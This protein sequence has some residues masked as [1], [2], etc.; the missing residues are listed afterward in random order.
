MLA[1]APSWRCLAILI[2][3]CSVQLGVA[4]RASA[5]EP[6]DDA[7]AYRLGTATTG[8]TYH[9]VGVALSTLVKL[10]LLPAFG[11]DLTAVNTEGSQQNLDLMRRNDIQFAIISALAGHEAR[12]GVGAFVDA[13]PDEDLRAITTLWLST[14]HLLIRDDAVRSGTIDDFLDLKGRP[15][16]LG[17]QNSSTLLE[18][19]TLMS[20]FGVDVDAD[21]DLVELGYGDSAEALA[22]GRIDGM[23]VSGGVPI[24]AVQDAFETLGSGVVA[25]EINDEQLAQIDDNRG[26]WQRVVV[27]SGTYPGQDRDIF[28]IGT[29]NI[30]AVRADVDDEVV[31]QITRTIFDE[32]D[33][34]HGLHST[35][36][37]ISLDNAVSNLPI[38][39]HAGAERYF[40]EK[41]VELTVPPIQLDPDLLVRYGT[42][43]EARIAANQGVVTMFG[44]T[45]GDTSSRIAAELAS[46]LNAD[47]GGLRLL[48]TNGGGVGRNLTDLLYLKGVDTA[49]VRAD[50]LAYARDQAVYPSLEGQVNYISEMFPEEVHLLVGGDIDDLDDLTGKKINVGAAASSDGVTASIVLS[51]LGLRADMTRFEPR[52]AIEKLKQGEIAGAIFVGGKPMP[53]LRQIER[54]AGLK[55]IAV[56]AVDY[57]DSYRSAEIPGRDY[58]NLMNPDDR[59]PTIAV[60]TALLTYAWPADSARYQA[61]SDLSGS[62]FGNLL[63][64]QSGGHHPK[65]REVDPTT[66]FASWRR[67]GPAARW[68]EDNLDTARRIA[69]EGRLQIELQDTDRAAAPAVVPVSL[70]DTDPSVPASGER[71]EAPAQR[72]ATPLEENGDTADIPT[73]PVV[74]LTPTIVEPD[75]DEPSIGGI[76]LNAAGAAQAAEPEPKLPDVPKTRLNKPTF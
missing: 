30:L 64:L 41:G 11:V 60:R 2:V 3:S 5:Q 19:Q 10:K 56:P 51:E 35:T 29:P 69:S 12:A 45:E 33:Y 14:D 9:P 72:A 40:K 13:G 4:S 49:L 74:E 26:I 25:L 21:F 18:N 43:E 42:S 66:E 31:Y 44:G 15:M 55:L 67:F 48:T 68:I 46:V 75:S 17:R 58:P 16:S 76:D 34:L 70:S 23:S 8:G 28:T 63:T 47:D 22:T 37:Q 59:V 7:G 50:M 62:L 27:P 1:R 53:L 57:A 20:A 24:G 65:W 54:D 52:M 61:L 71:S 38:P 39:V 32:L 6:V 36:R 73:A